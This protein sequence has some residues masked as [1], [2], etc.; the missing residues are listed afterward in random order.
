MLSSRFVRMATQVS[1]I[2]CL[3]KFWIFGVLELKKKSEG[4]TGSTGGS[5]RIGGRSSSSSSSCAVKGG[6]V[7]S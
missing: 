3:E 1:L 6:V 7:S 2:G 5:V 4:S